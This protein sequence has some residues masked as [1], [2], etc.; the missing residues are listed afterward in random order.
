MHLGSSPGILFVLLASFGVAACGGDNSSPTSATP[1]RGEFS[2]TDIRV[3]TGADATPMRQLT[4]HYT[5]WLY[6]PARPEQKGSQFETSIGREPFA[7]TLGGG[8]VIRG[9]D[10][11]VAGMKFGGLRRL[12]LPP[13]LAYGGAGSP[14]V[15]PPNATLV[16]DIELLDVQ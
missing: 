7:F 4:V 2:Q 10:Q 1:P 8:R 6:D 14:P 12:V 11:G 13:E 9:W 15:I 5:G 3:G 16:F